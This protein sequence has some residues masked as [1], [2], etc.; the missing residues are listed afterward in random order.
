M[1]FV[2]YMVG[3]G[4]AIYYDVMFVLIPLL[5]LELVSMTTMMI[6][7]NIG[8]VF[9]SPGGVIMNMLLRATLLGIAL[10]FGVFE[11]TQWVLGASLLVLCIYLFSISRKF[12]TESETT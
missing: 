3:F 9:L 1:I 7:A 2:L 10:S 4:S 12:L 8:R 11:P 6:S 5:S